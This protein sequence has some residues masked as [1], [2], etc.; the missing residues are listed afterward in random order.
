EHGAEATR[1][2]VS[3]QNSLEDEQLER[4]LG[5]ALLREEHLR[6]TARPETSDDLEIGESLGRGPDLRIAHGREQTSLLPFS[7]HMVTSRAEPPR[8]PLYAFAHT[9]KPCRFP[10]FCG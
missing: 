10:G 1:R 2:T 8:R 3:R 5:A 9:R 4:A 6:H 7:I